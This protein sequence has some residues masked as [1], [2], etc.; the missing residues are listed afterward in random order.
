[1]SNFVA[2]EPNTLDLQTEHAEIK[3]SVFL[4]ENNVAFL[5]IDHLEELLKNIFPDSKICK[6]IKLKR[7]KATNIIKNVIAPSE[8]DGLVEKLTS[9]KFSI[10]VDNQLI[11]VLNLICV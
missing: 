2:N 9:S 6:Q 4:A 7:T 11:L 3:L 8:K 10:V 5:V 1:M